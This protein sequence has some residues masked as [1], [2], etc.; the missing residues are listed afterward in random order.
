MRTALLGLLRF[1]SG[2]LPRLRFSSAQERQMH[3]ED[4]DE[5][6]DVEDRLMVDENV[7]VGP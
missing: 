5:D 2:A 1:F 6:D 4:E 7:V 3:V